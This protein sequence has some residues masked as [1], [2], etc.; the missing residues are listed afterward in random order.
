MRDLSNILEPVLLGREI[1]EVEQAAEGTLMEKAGSFIAEFVCGTMHGRRVLVLVGPGNNGGD[2]FIAAR[3][4]KS[5]WFDVTVVF[6]G[7]ADWLPKEAAQARLAWLDCG[8]VCLGNIPAGG[9]WDFAI[10]GL[11]GTGLTRQ[12]SEPYRSMIDALNAL[13]LPVIAIDIP[14]GICADTGTVLGAAV[15]ASHTLTFIAYKP[16]LLTSDGLD[17]CGKVVLDRLGLSEAA[18]TRF[19]GWRTGPEILG[20]SF[21]RRP[22]NSHKGSFGSTAIIGGS[23][24]ML[25]AALLAARAALKL[26]SGK[27]ILCASSILA[28]DP[29]QPEIMIGDAQQVMEEGASTIVVGPGLGKSDAARVL[30]DLALSSRLPLVLDADALNLVSGDSALLQRLKDRCAVT[31]LTPHPLEAARLMGCPTSDIQKDRVNAAKHMAER[32]GCPVVLKGAGS[33]CAFPDGTWAINT[34]GNPGMAAPGMG[35]VLSGMIGAFLSQGVAPEMALLCAVYLHG[36]AAERLSEAWGGE[37][38]MTATEVIDR[39]RALLNGI[40]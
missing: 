27:V 18:L 23:C 39:A 17:H 2:A 8:G 20:A 37:I 32:F 34:S 24:G 9:K 30:V 10:D 21:N 22:R 40:T 11:F 29:A 12:I 16:G 4:L 14:S 26:G 13:G 28:V 7:E 36:A 1:R 15:L 19:Q 6:A 31:I 38:G 35:D 3:H 25:G 5:S 33:V